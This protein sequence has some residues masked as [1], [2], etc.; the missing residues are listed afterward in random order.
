MD[1]NQILTVGRPV[2]DILIIVL[3]G[4]IAKESKPLVAK[5][6]EV[7]EKINVKVEQEIG[8]NN[9]KYLKSYVED[10]YKAN[11]D[12][13]T[14]ANIEA[15]TAKIIEKFLPKISEA[16]IKQVIDIVIKDA[17]IALK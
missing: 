15:V 4:Y 10:L 13:F 6:L 11:K 9:Y 16:T 7:L 14:E 1:I 17:E 2:L 3:I 8:T 12:A 5:G